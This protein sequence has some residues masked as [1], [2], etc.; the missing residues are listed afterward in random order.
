MKTAK[1]RVIGD[2]VRE[3]KGGDTWSRVLKFG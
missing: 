2:E 1:E 3:L